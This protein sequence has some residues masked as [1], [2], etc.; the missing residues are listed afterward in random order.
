MGFNEP[1][2]AEAEAR[3]ALQAMLPR[4]A[5]SP[6]A[7]LGV[8]VDAT[9]DVLRSSFLRLTKQYHPTKYARFSPDVVR[10]AN[11]VFLTIKRAYDQ[12]SPSPRRLAGGTGVRTA[13]RQTASGTAPPP[14]RPAPTTT[15]NPR[16]VT[17]VGPAPAP[18]VTRA[19]PLASRPA[20]VPA[21]PVRPATP[22][23]GVP[24]V[25]PPRPQTARLATPPMGVPATAPRAPTAKVAPLPPPPP[26]AP[27]PTPA[28][29]REAEFAAAIDLL[30]RKL[31]A[32]ARAV[33]HK[34]AAAV[35]SDK[36]FRAHMHYARG[37]EADVAGKPDE[38]RA[39]WQRAVALDPEFVRARSALADLSPPPG[40]GL[41][42]RLFK[43]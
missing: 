13:V 32:E 12:L 37:C 19:P 41:F 14:T 18:P 25:V 17:N 11:E 10:L 33:F 5:E 26:P 39:E 34:L 2:T 16:A 7:L 42:S 9:A 6:H 4:L 3:T 31:F 36:R 1:D 8:P 15:G 27:A 24:A 38:A 20:P 35:P 43:K 22:P 30:R 23:M 29:L 40:G 28:A 21:R